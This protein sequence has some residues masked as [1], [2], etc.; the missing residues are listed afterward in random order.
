MG[1][2]D[3][4][5]EWRVRVHEC[6][7][8]F[9]NAGRKKKHTKMFTEASPSLLPPDAHCHP[10]SRLPANPNRPSPSP[11]KKLKMQST[12]GSMQHSR[13]AK[14]PLSRELGQIG[15]EF[16]EENDRLRLFMQQY[17]RLSPQPPADH[18]LP[19]PSLARKIANQAALIQ[20][21]GRFTPIR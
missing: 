3:S 20:Q 13:V 18:P 2:G 16:Q 1:G 17:W 19:R 7:S 6:Y 9:G 10:S 11:P 14:P 12:E 8:D 5:E 4:G 21:M 15:Q